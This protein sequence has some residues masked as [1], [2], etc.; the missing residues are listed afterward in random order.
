M[1]V[2]IYSLIYASTSIDL[3]QV[4]KKVQKSSIQSHTD[5]IAIDAKKLLKADEVLIMVMNSHTGKIEAL[6]SS[7]AK[8][9]AFVS[10][11][12][13]PGSVVMPITMAIALDAGLVHENE[14]INLHGG[15][16][17][18]NSFTI[19]D[20]Q[21]LDKPLD[22]TGVITHSSKVGIVQIA[23]RL[24]DTE[25]FAGFESF[26]LS[27]IT[28]V[29]SPSFI[30]TAYGYSMLVTPIQMM[31]AYAS[32]SNGGK[33]VLP[34]LYHKPDASH[35]R[36]LSFRTAQLIKRMLI[37]NVKEGTG[38]N[39]DVSG[40]T[41]GG[42]TST[43]HISSNAHH[44]NAYNSSFFGFVEDRGGNLYT[45]GVIV[46]NPKGIYLASQTAAPVFRKIVLTMRHEGLLA[47]VYKAQKDNHFV[48]FFSPPLKN[49]NIIH[50]YGKYRDSEYNLSVFNEGILL[51]PAH[52]RQEVYAVE[53]GTVSFVG[54]DPLLG[55]T[56]VI[57]HNNSKYKS[58]YAGLY[59][60]NSAIY[61]GVSVSKNTVIGRAGRKLTFQLV[62]KG[63]LVDPE[64]YIHFKDFQ[65]KSK[66]PNDANEQIP[67]EIIVNSEASASNQYFSCTIYSKRDHNKIGTVI[68]P[69]NKYQV[70]KRKDT[71]AEIVGIYKANDDNYYIDAITT[72]GTKTASCNACQE[73]NVETFKVTE[74]GLISMR[75]RPFNIDT[76]TP[77]K[78]IKMKVE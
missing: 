3:A 38:K 65:T 42:K 68:Q 9:D 4:D 64:K 32:F 35:K 69:I 45:I 31:R 19:R 71:E 16:I 11:A 70:H 39:A 30:A 59:S 44:I 60:V 73:Y 1:F 6:S 48:P 52:D 13:E 36:I 78:A 40:F 56:I 72:K 28:K 46:R 34:Y 5:K 66:A 55:K 20:E 49:C 18:V 10:W 15:S 26:G 67:Y 41:I 7:N 75:L 33:A 77:Y 25:L 14:Q 57:S 2:G 63:D 21:T 23:Q 22:I 51:A 37:A 74:A 58:V 17:R 47:K 53:K 62:H 61:K 50:K 24:S 8:S 43:A 27:K 76:Y 54:N 12:Y 29:G